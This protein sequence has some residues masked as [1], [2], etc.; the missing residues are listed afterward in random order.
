MEAK[1]EDQKRNADSECIEKIGLERKTLQEEF[2]LATKRRKA[3]CEP[4]R[5]ELNEKI[6]QYESKLISLQSELVGLRGRH[7]SKEN[8]LTSIIK[9]KESTITDAETKMRELAAS[10]D[11]LRSELELLK[12]KIEK[13]SQVK[14]E[15]VAFVKL[16]QLTSVPFVKRRSEGVGRT[17]VRI[18]ER[19]TWITCTF[20][21][22]SFLI[23]AA[24]QNAEREARG[25]NSE[26]KG[27]SE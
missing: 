2:K 11:S 16:I 7:E 1:L 5:N 3:E 18:S 25:R 23:L 10:R 13:E 6:G 27:S 21:I 24:K 17:A 26:S 20:K 8:E 4:K 22:S 12:H 14:R 19:K 9:C 15:A